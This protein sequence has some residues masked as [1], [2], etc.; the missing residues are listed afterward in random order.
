MKLATHSLAL[1]LVFHTWAIAFTLPEFHEQFKLIPQPQKIELIPGKGLSYKELL[2]VCLADGVKRPV[3]TGLLANLPQVKFKSLGSVSLAINANLGLPSPEGYQL[4]I[5]DGM[6]FIEAMDD[7]GLFYGIQTLSQLLEDAQDQQ[8]EIPACRITDYPE[9]AY[10]AVH[11]DLKHH[12]DASHYYY[13]IIDRLASIKVNAI[14]IEFED[15]LRYRK[16][17]LVASPNAISIEEFAAMSKYAKERHIEISPLIQGLGHASFILKHDEYKALRDDPESDWVFDPLNPGTYDLQFSLYED[18]IAATPYGKYLHVGGDEVGALGKSALSKAS[19]MKPIELQMY[20]LKKVTTFAQQHNR[21]PIF[22]DDMVFKLANL[23]QT[24]YDSS[25]PADEVA[26]RWKKNA[27]LLVESL[28]LFPEVCAYMRWNYDDPMLL[29]N[30]MAIDWYKA[31]N[32]T[33]M[34]ATSAQPYSSMFPNTIMQFEPI[35]RFCRLTSEKKMSGIL[36]TIWDDTSPHLEV[37][38]RGVFDFALFSWNYEDI[39]IDQAHAL[40]QQRFYAAALAKPS[41]NFQDLLEQSTTPFWAT[42]FLQE[43]DREI[44]HK[45]FSLI[46]LPDPKNKGMWSK[47]YKEKLS[48]AGVVRAQQTE[49]A[50][51]IVEAQQVTRRN[52]YALSLFNVINEFQTYTSEMLILLQQYDQAAEKER[53]IKALR[54]KKQLEEFPEI[55]ARFEDEYGKTRMMVN[56]PGYKLDS[57]FHH[58]LANGTNSSDWIFIYE[59]AMNKKITD[60]LAQLTL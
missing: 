16:S 5:V 17:P 34:A 60:W 44:Y 47:T 43:G 20:W 56:P 38:S 8:L 15:K 31:H 6:V 46:A 58:H 59:I 26:E 4:E 30:Q 54:V 13:T 22:W 14:I 27:P 48:K 52:E 37:I 53:T 25:I 1:V 50:K 9:I 57:N 55:R 21:I 19:G 32:L 36:C 12:L 7:A 33:V 23:Y 45:T 51:Q 35:K 11:L 3:M 40:F 10:R 24:T 42:A 2:G 39:P 28:P 41:F 49:I 29:G 18:A